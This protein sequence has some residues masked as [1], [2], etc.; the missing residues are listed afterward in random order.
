ML[1]YFILI[2]VFIPNYNLYPIW[3]IL[4]F[5]LI[6]GG[7]GC[8]SDLSDSFLPVYVPCQF[9]QIYPEFTPL[10]REWCYN[11]CPSILHVM[12]WSQ[13]NIIY[14]ALHNNF[15]VCQLIFLVLILSLFPAYVFALIPLVS[16][17]WII[18]FNNR[19]NM[20]LCYNMIRVR[21]FCSMGLLLH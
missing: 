20:I 19:L 16:I 12:E 1:V 8:E 5:V 3:I 4:W 9:T 17:Y 7:E 13:D 6:W 14:F 21:L 11:G 10:H 2:W 15:S 18:C